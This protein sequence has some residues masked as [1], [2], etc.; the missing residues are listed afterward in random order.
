MLTPLFPSSPGLRGEFFGAGDVC[1]GGGGGV[2]QD[3]GWQRGWDG[4]GRGQGQGA[5][6]CTLGGSVSST[7]HRGTAAAGWAQCICG[8]GM[9]SP[10]PFLGDDS[11]FA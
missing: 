11:G 9:V 4:R 8:A 1:G 2:G 7:A 6:R 10:A 3:V 5:M